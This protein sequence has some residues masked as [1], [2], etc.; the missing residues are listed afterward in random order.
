MTVNFNAI[1]EELRSRPQWVL[2]RWVERPDKTTGELKWT[3]P[4]YQPNGISAKSNNPSTWVSFVEA[5]AAYESGGFSGIGYVVTADTEATDR[6]PA[7]VDDG[8]SGVDLDHVVDPETGRI[9]PWAQSI[10]DDL[11]SYAEISPSGTGLR[12][13]VFAKLPPK[14]RKV[15]NFECYES[16]R[17]M[18][19]TGNHLPGTP[20]TI[21]KRQNEMTAVHAEMFHER[22]KK[23]PKQGPPPE[24]TPVDLDDDALLDVA[25][26]SKN[27]PAVRQLYHG[28]TAQYVSPSEADL[29]LCSYLAFYARGDAVRVD[30][31]FRASKLWRPQ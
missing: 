15:G 30:R 28:D 4:P 11:N 5:K 23:P 21:E 12:I 6:H 17:Y 27:G 7:L 22:N 1:P 29:A 31:M 25:F 9:E 8:I 13:F 10:V 18:T 14:D 2:W 24:A 26:R 16:G 3:K 19:V 20:A